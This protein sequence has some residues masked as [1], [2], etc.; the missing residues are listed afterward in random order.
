[1]GLC[2]L[3]KECNL[4]RPEERG[5]D[6]GAREMR[7]GT[8]SPFTVTLA[9]LRTPPTC[10]GRGGGVRA[11]ALADWTRGAHGGSGPALQGQL[12]GPFER[13][14]GPQRPE[15]RGRRWQRSNGDGG[16]QPPSPGPRPSARP[17]SGHPPACRPGR[18]GREGQPRG[19]AGREAVGLVLVPPG[20]LSLDLA[21]FR[22]P[23]APRTLAV[24]H[25]GGG[26]S[27]PLCC[28]FYSSLSLS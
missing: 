7:P 8:C 5:G 11:K 24:A 16:R 10:A 1:M 21:N 17:A 27:R 9:E 19:C 12:E 25:G 26:F 6:G 4:T 18:G 28:S 3:Q 13:R 15:A 2:L 14:G 23:S 22:G 20:L